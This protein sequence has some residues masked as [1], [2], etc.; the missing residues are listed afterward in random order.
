MLSW[1]EQPAAVLRHAWRQGLRAPL[2]PD[3]VFST[4]PGWFTTQVDATTGNLL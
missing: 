1:A 2:S 4:P 3:D